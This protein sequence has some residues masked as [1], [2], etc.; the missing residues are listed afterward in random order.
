M[1]AVYDFIPLYCPNCAA[2]TGIAQRNIP[3]DGDYL[4][5]ASSQCTCGLMFAYVPTSLI[6]EAATKAK[7]DLPRY[8]E[9][10]GL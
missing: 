10:Q 6:L 1:I 8:A 2:P 3:A 9:E 4:V 7:S 5:G